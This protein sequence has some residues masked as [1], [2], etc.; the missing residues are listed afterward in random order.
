MH[1]GSERAIR[2]EMRRTGNRSRKFW[3]IRKRMM[4]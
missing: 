2:G 3:G 1:P 4:G